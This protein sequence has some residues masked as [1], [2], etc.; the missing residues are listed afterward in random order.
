VLL[1]GPSVRAVAASGARVVMAVSSRGCAAAERLPGVAEVLEVELPWI[2]AEPEAYDVSAHE[3]LVQ[4]FAAVGATEGI[5]LTSFHQ[6]ALPTA[7]VLRLAGVE[8]LVAVSEDYPGSLLDVRVAPPP[9]MHEV[10][11]MLAVVGAAGYQL[12]ADDD[13]GL[14]IRYDER[15]H[16]GG[17]PYVVVHPGASVPAR[18]L[19]PRA[20][21]AAVRELARRWEV[22]VTG[23]PGDAAVVEE[24]MAGHPTNV[25]RAAGTTLDELAGLV[26]GAAAVVVGNTGP[27]HLAAA[28]GTPVVSIFAPTVD[29]SAWRPWGVPH[30]LLGRLDIECAGCRSRVCPFPGQPCLAAV[31][32]VVIANAVDELVGVA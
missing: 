6:S 1:A 14:R 9:P 16:P 12:P 8:R 24:V 22:V 11:R 15:Q 17:S 13:G 18:T 30:R 5:V 19:G 28:V 25:R 4:S 23:G 32:P 20:W 27:A 31:T 26:A 21:R 10:E 29:S 7:V 3:H 2:A